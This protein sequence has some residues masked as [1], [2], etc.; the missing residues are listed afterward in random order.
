MNLE[1][2]MVILVIVSFFLTSISVLTVQAGPL[3]R[4]EAIEISKNSALVQ[5]GLA[6]SRYTTIQAHYYNSSML[7]QLKEWHSDEIFEN[8]PKDAFW[9]EKVP[10]G[11][12]VWEILWSFS[13]GVGGYNIGV[14][15]D[16]ET[17]TIITEVIGV[18][19]G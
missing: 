17:G 14:I 13:E 16:A 15:V 3:T 19:F 10:E 8:V 6:K 12:S 11:H 5:E 2:I 4:E 1:K 18:R 9:E 7:E